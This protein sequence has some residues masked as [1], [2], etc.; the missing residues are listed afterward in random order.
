MAII[1]VQ[2]VIIEFCNVNEP[3]ARVGVF[4]N[5]SRQGP[6]RL[7]QEGIVRVAYLDNHVLRLGI[8]PCT[9]RPEA[10]L[11]RFSTCPHYDQPTCCDTGS[12]HDLIVGGQ[13]GRRF[14]NL[15]PS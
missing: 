14:P 7:L 12:A 13:G 9:S 3:A 1:V 6:D 4:I 10:D 11:R 5:L 8:L 2:R 15:R